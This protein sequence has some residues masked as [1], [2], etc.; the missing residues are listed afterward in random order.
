MANMEL[1][2]AIKSEADQQLA[3]KQIEETRK[4]ADY[5]TIDYPVETI[6]QKYLI[7]EENDENE[8]YVPDYQRDF[9]WD[10]KRQSK[11]V[12]SVLLGLPIQPI[13]V[14]DRE[15][16][17]EIVDGSQRIRTLAQ[18]TSNLLMLNE[19]KKLDK[20]NGF[21][22]CDL[23]VIRQRRF[24]KTPL[25]MVS[26]TEKAD[27]DVVLDI[28][29]RLNTGADELTAME[30]RKGLWASRGGFYNLLSECAQDAKFKAL[31]PISKK[32]A[33]REEGEELVLRFFAYSERYQEFDH[34][35]HVFVTQYMENKK[36]DFDGE[37]MKRD[38]HA[39]LNFVEKYFPFGF[40]KVENAKSTPRVRFEAIAVGVHLAI[41]QEPNLVPPPVKGWIDSEE[42]KD[43][44]RSDASND[45][46]KIIKRIEYV[47]DHLLGTYA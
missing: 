29:E 32:R 35:V 38:F 26:L 16:R 47:R 31:C 23:P 2:F 25:R 11:F 44:T 3:E 19:L 45:R 12:E 36:D 18:F 28:F 24:G 22:F 9:V 1:K 33:I 37:V 5:D 46:L 14:A 10:E 40:R 8:L 21:R 42:F 30:I 20:L 6:V 15:G 41:K 13:F 4:I 27:P 34:R 43:H 17:L 7:G 39:V